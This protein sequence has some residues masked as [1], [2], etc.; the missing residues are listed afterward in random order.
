M[1]IKIEQQIEVYNSEAEDY[2][3][4]DFDTLFNKFSEMLYN[5]AFYYLNDMEVAKSIVN[6]TF[7]RV[8]NVERKPFNIKSYLYRSVK[9]ACFNYLSQNQNKVVFK[10]SS[11]LEIL[12][13]DTVSLQHSDDSLDKLLFLEQVILKLPVKRQI[14]FKMFRFEELSYAEIAELLNISVRTVEDHLA[15]SMQFIHEQAKHFIN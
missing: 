3:S 8:W 5:Y 11:E 2:N 12:S 13:D 1:N 10:E 9:N 14:V 7:L 6:D 15:K 4:S